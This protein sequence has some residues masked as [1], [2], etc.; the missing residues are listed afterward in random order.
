MGV[1]LTLNSDDTATGTMLLAVS[2]QAADAAG[3][4][5]AELLAEMDSEDLGEGA[6]KVQDYAEDGFTGKRYVFEG[7]ALTEVADENCPTWF[8]RRASAGRQP[9]SRQRRHQPPRPTHLLDLRRRDHPILTTRARGEHCSPRA[10]SC[11]L[12]R[13]LAP[14]GLSSRSPCRELT[15]CSNRAAPPDF[16]R[17][18]SI[19]CSPGVRSSTGR[20]RWRRQPTRASP[21]H[22]R[23]AAA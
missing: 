17:G 23:P 21:A 8:G 4:T 7:S 22:P 11:V 1:D 5:S 16:R 9:S 13:S 6:A 15:R 3:M 19:V 20:T 18:R 12:S 2:D 10:L 14:Q